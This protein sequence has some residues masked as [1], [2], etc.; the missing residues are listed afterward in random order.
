MK[1]T[2][3]LGFLLFVACL[4]YCLWTPRVATN[5]TAGSFWRAWRDN[6]QW[7][8]ARYVGVEFTLTGT[9]CG[10][11]EKDGKTL[12][13]MCPNVECELPARY[14]QEVRKLHSGT[15]VRVVGT[16]CSMN[17]LSSCKSLEVVR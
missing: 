1:T 14:E 11:A 13:F 3:Y 6:D 2:F 17:K 8:E 16:C 10:Y 9:A 4:G 15:T 12:L 5:Q 7:C